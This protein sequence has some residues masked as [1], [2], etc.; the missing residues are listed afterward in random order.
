MGLD[1]YAQAY[2][3]NAT[4]EERD[5]TEN[6]AYWRKHNALHSAME[7]LYYKKGGTGEFNCVDVMLNAEDLNNLEEAIVA[8]TLK[9]A[10]GFFFGNTDYTDADWEY[11]EKG[12]LKFIKDAREL[13]AEGNN[14]FYHAWY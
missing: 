8:R 7:T 6:F 14:I 5:N 12:D 3:P 1:M 2:K 10:S 4:Q 11:H 13:L 9:P